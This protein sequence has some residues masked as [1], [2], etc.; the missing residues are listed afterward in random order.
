MQQ[1]AATEFKAGATEN[2]EKEDVRRGAYNN[3]CF[4][5]GIIVLAKNLSC[6]IIGDGCIIEPNSN[7][8]VRREESG[9]IPQIPKEK[10]MV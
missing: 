3:C 9:V 8:H 2:L 10:G 4:Q 1:E 5:G 7:P 6:Q